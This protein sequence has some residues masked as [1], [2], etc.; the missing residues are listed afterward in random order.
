LK[1][2]KRVISFAAA[3][4]VA[5]LGANIAQAAPG[6]GRGH[7][8][9][10]SHRHHFVPRAVF[11]APLYAYPRYYYPPPYLDYYYPSPL[12]TYIEQQ[13]P[14]QP[15]VAPQIHSGALWYCPAAGAYY[16]SAPSCPGGWQRVEPPPPP[17]D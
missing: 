1:P 4:L 3:L 9:S 10:H 16:P 6:H 8:H 14:A 7:S 5:G 12:V 17:G 11:F 13:P 15:G 2:G